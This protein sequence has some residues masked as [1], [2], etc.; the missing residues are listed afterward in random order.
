MGY[1]LRKGDSFCGGVHPPFYKT[2]TEEKGL[3]S[4]PPPSLAVFPLQQHVGRPAS[5]LVK[6]GA[7]VLIGEKIGESGGYISLPV[8]ASISGI[9]KEIRP[10]PH[11]DGREV[12]SVLVESDGEDEW[13]SL[14]KDRDYS[15][16][17]RE[18][19]CARVR[20]AGISGMG[21]ASF[22]SHVKLNPPK[23]VDT[24]IINGCECEPFLTCDDKLMI[25]YSRKIVEGARIIV[26]A[27]GADRC[28]FAIEKNKP[29][30]IQKMEEALFHEPNTEL[31]ALKTKYPQGA[32][33]QLIKSLLNK[34]V[35]SG[36]LPFE[37]GVVVHNVGTAYAIY[38]AVVKGI[39]LIKR[40]VTVTGPGI[41]EPRDLW[42]RLGTPIK[43]LIEHC[44]GLK[45]ETG[46]V[47]I[48]GPM[49]GVAQYHL[50][51][52]VIKGTS[53]ILVMERGAEQVERDCIKCSRC[54]DVCPVRLLPTTIA[55]F[56]KHR[57]WEKVKQYDALDCIECGSCAYICPSS[58]PL[59][60]YIKWGKNRIRKSEK[61]A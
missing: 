16:F 60:Q 61:K 4:L 23:E 45:G 30:A 42:V 8:H 52:P 35:P 5:P 29:R 41:S 32:E 56:V 7:R 21:G 48:G 17:S 20:E 22:P 18:E 11:P 36:G 58:I 44:G 55:R 51:V 54:V 28:M 24:V 27:V 26:Q 39:P 38:E 13:V 9:V 40:V 2:F 14:F 12:L 53:G 10:F 19:L 49:M 25:H 34:E 43:Q 33:K 31:V 3:E 6:E 1:K 15:R 46:K 57:N 59:V 37:V 50:D 47:I